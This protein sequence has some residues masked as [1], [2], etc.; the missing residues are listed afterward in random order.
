MRKGALRRD[1]CYSEKGVMSLKRGTFSGGIS[2]LYKKELARDKPLEVMREPERV[3]VPLKQHIGAPCTPLVS[4]GDDVTVGQKIAESEHFV[5]SPVHA[6]IS[7][8][9]AEITGASVVIEGTGRSAF[10]SAVPRNFEALSA[11]EIRAA[12]REAGIVGLGGAAFPTHVK[13]TP[14]RGNTF[15]YVLLNGA[16]CEPYLTIDERIMIE[17]ADRVV[18]GARV[19]MKGVGAPK[20]VIGVEEDKEAALLS[21]RKAV[22]VFPEISVAP[23]AVKYPQGGE[24]M[25]IKSL[26]GRE[27]PVGGLPV[28]VGALVVNVGTAVAAADAVT[29]GRPLYERGITVTGGGVKEP[30]N[31][32]VRIGVSFA[33]VLDYCGGL[34]PDAVRVIAGGPLMG[35]AVVSLDEVVVKG[36][37]GILAL[38]AEE[39]KSAEERVC[40]RCGRC[41][42]AC[43]MFLT[44]NAFA[45]CSR[46]ALLDEALDL[47]IRSCIECGCCDYVCPSRIPLVH[48]IR[49]C[50]AEIEA[51]KLAE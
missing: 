19:L 40:I 4:K 30:K 28:D 45:V 37:S 11:E 38:T 29:E 27:V 32:V 5:S 2:P 51:R 36:T 14:P 49:R 17:K 34:A 16:E 6:S 7:G 42:D 9:V 26:L 15:E 1:I 35:R 41:V 25:L 31:L 23:L 22:S 20:A 46:N 8:R 39:A 18:A 21:L 43:P 13:M 33:E 12:V 24:K 3:S 44:P 48:L 50:K 47:D 10:S